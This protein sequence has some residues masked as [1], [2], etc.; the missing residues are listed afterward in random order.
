MPDRHPSSRTTSTIDSPASHRRAS[1]SW[2]PSQLRMP[3]PLDARSNS[4]FAGSRTAT[5]EVAN[6]DSAVTRRPRLSACDERPCRPRRRR[7]AAGR[8]R[9]RTGRPTRRRLRRPRG[10]PPPFVPQACRSAGGS[11]PTPGGRWRRE[12]RRSAGSQVRRRA[13]A[14][15]SGRRGRFRM[16]VVCI[17]AERRTQRRVVMW[18]SQRSAALWIGSYRATISSSSPK[19]SS[20]STQPVTW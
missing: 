17:V 18:R 4:A 6:T 2:T 8:A 7:V 15:R 11:L 13:R 9:Q 10:A 12:R 20:V 16:G 19:P 3:P 14:G 5:D 1:M